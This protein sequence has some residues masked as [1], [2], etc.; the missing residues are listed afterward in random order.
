MNECIKL[1]GSIISI[2]SFLPSPCKSPAQDHGLFYLSKTPP[3]IKGIRPT[4]DLVVLGNY[5]PFKC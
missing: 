2:N 1:Y 5:R 4:L 3:L